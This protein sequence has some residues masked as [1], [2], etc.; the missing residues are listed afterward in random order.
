MSSLYSFYLK[1]R[2]DLET[3]QVDSGFAV[4]KIIEQS[5]YIKD[6]YVV[7]QL[8]RTGCAS[9]MA[10]G[11]VLIAKQKGCKDMIGSVAPQAHD[12]TTSMKVLLAYGFSFFK[13]VQD[14]IL[15]RKEI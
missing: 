6:I 12:P 7:P 10:D 14:L 5:L 11:L 8:R 1:E 4:Y 15:F 9:T 3:F 2:E 13:I